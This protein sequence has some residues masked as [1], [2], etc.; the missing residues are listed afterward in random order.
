MLLDLNHDGITDFV[1][2]RNLSAHFSTSLRIGAYNN[3]NRTW[4]SQNKKNGQKLAS[5]LPAGLRIRNSPHFSLGFKS[6]THDKLMWFF[7]QSYTS[8]HGTHCI[9]DGSGQW[10]PNTNRYLGLKF[11]IK[12]KT[13]YGWARVSFIKGTA[14]LLS[15]AYETIPNKP[16]KADQTH[17][18]DEATLG[19]LATGDSAWHV[20]QTAA[21][22]H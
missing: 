17:G 19:R 21:T 16:I 15:Y 12:R 2:Q 6:G 3:S 9:T 7:F 11:Q 22:I 14:T 20:K 5:A 4:G 13:H 10:K 8:T 18:K 1:F